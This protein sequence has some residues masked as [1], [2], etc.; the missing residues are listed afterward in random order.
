MIER[1]YIMRMINQLTQVLAK[2]LFQRK[3]YEFPQARRELEAAYKSMLGLSPEFVRQFS[4]VQM[5]EMF[6]RDEDTMVLKTYILGSLLK[7]EGEILLLE[8]KE[9]DSSEAFIR[10]LSLLLTAFVVAKNEA[11][12]GHCSTIEGLLSRLQE[13]E[14]PVHVKEKLLTYDELTGKYDK[15][16]DVLFDLAGSD[17]AWVAPGLTFYERLLKRSD[18]ELVAGGL[19]RAEVLDGMK[20]LRE[21]G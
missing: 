2:V 16:E 1:D 4:D 10:S 11:Q 15:A 8:G 7:E 19:P 20:E 12:V 17:V 13:L 21:M 9:V 6:G 18:D 5:I 3:A 14:I